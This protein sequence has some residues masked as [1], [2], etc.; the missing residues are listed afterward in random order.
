MTVA[1]VFLVLMLLLNAVCVA[2]EYSIVSVRRS[3]VRATAEG[4]SRL[5][6]A[7][8]PFLEHAQH[9]DRYI[10][11]CQLGI[12]VTSL[13]VGMLAEGQL[14]EAVSGWFVDL[15]DLQPDAYS[16]AVTT[17]LV[18]LES[19]VQ[20]TFTE[21]L[22]KAIA[23]QHPEPMAMGTSPVVRFWLAMLAMPIRVFTWSSN[24]VLRV[25][26]LPRP[27]ENQEHVYSA[28]E[29]LILVD[30]SRRGGVLE[31][32]TSRRL[33]HAL[34]L[35]ERPVRRLMV[36][37][38]RVFAV[39][40]AQ[41]IEQAV[42]AIMGS[43]HT[44]VPV[45][46]GDTDAIVGSIHTKDLAMRYVERGRVDDV[47]DLIR[48]VLFVPELAPAEHVLAEMR[49]KNVAQGVVIDEFGSLVGLLTL[50]DLLAD[51]VGS[52]RLGSPKVPAVERLPDGR[53]RI[54]GTMRLEDAVRVVGAPWSG[55]ANTVS[56]FVIERLGRLPRRGEACTLDGIDIEVEAVLRHVVTS[57]LAK[58]IVRPPRRE[59]T[60]G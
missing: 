26:R 47:V 36:P 20:V 29:L 18:V 49:G 38:N 58:P 42:A 31:A 1:V 27:G 3:R 8:L 53:V 22:P 54:P 13:G 4:G 39:D 55:Y 44:R 17:V 5:A 21:V 10:S 16:L 37:R 23:L 32:A 43:N 60:R 34:E 57:I 56:G 2:A 14:A 9:K 50:E 40:L 33:R 28:N 19:A 52:S 48:P 45:Y 30:E 11:G 24:G 35:K 12:T 25:L 6:Q 41:P 15:G 59:A 51:V 46:R 7:L